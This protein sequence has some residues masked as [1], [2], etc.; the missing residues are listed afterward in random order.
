LLSAK[1]RSRPIPVAPVVLL[2]FDS[3]PAATLHSSYRS[4]PAAYQSRE[5]RVILHQ[6]LFP[7]LPFDV[8]QAALAREIAHAALHRHP[9]VTVHPAYR[10]PLS[11]EIVTDQLVCRWG[12]LSELQQER[13]VCRG[14]DPGPGVGNAEILPD[15]SKSRFISAILIALTTILQVRISFSLSRPAPQRSSL[16]IDG[17]VDFL[18]RSYHL[19]ELGRRAENHGS[20][21]C[22][23][24]L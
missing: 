15:S 23:I 5:H 3:L 6:G 12:F 7:A 22:I 11:E 14:D 1:R 8:Q 24:G 10:I 20:R 13:I 18:Y 4:T 21:L 19:F 2:D 16:L 17:V 9:I